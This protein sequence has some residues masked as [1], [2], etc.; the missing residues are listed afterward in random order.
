MPE[1]TSDERAHRPED[2]APGEAAPGR[3]PAAAPAPAPLTRGLLAGEIVL[4]LA[5]SLGAAAVAAVISFVGSLTAPESLAEQTASLIGSQAAEQR[6]WLDLSR[7]LASLVFAMAPVALAVYLLHRTR[8]SAATIGFDVT[9]PGRDL[10]GGAALA[11]LIGG[12]GLVVYV[13]SH[14]LGLSVTVAPSSLNDHWWTVPVLLLQAVKN[15]VLEEV[16]VVGY[17]M[18]RLDQLGWS[19]LRAAVASSLLRAS[20][21]I[22]QGLGMFFG[23]LVMGL[24]FC[25]FYRRYGRVMPLVAAHS[26]IDIVAFVGSVYVLG[27]VDWLPGAGG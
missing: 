7:Q 3:G 2:D 11:A 10:L 1:P 5:L 15:G 24:V 20:Y 18:L 13:V 6:P 22:Y 14:Q 16:I 17:L 25:W 26:L 23:N 9:R 8:E 27:R 4:V 21:H 19:P 12:G